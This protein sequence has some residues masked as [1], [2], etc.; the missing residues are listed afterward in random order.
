MSC[1]S[2]IIG[3]TSPRPLLLGLPLLLLATLLAAGVPSRA[4]T[5]QQTVVVAVLPPVAQPGTDPA[6]PTRALTVVVATFRP[7]VQHRP[8]YLEVRRDGRW[9]PV[10]T[11]HLDA[12]GRVTFTARQRVD[13]EVATYRVRTPAYGRLSEVRSAPVRADAWGRPAFVDGFGGTT[14][15]P[16]W[17]HRIQFYNPWGGRSCSKGDPAA[18]SVGGGTLQLS[19]LADPARSGELCQPADAE[20]NPTASG[21]YDWRLNGHVSTQKSFDFQYGVAAARMRFQHPRGQHAAFWLQPRGL[22]DTGPTPWGAEIDVIEWYGADRDRGRMATAVH[23]HTNG[24]SDLQTVGGPIADPERFLDGRGDRWWRG[25]HVFSVEWTPEEY[26]FRIDGRETLRTTRNVS[27]HPEF[28]ILSMLSSD[29]ELGALGADAHLPQQ[30]DVDW[31][32]VWP[33]ASQEAGGL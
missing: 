12:R 16:A 2:R 5:A 8:A 7:R 17:Q 1:V 21:S 26:V 13:G 19:V 11:E 32:A 31:V 30:T 15:G 24:G 29:Y 20:G 33:G 10:A 23:R 27:H 28:L 6:S 3:L 18:V 22:L 25:Y 4:A 14:L 9:R